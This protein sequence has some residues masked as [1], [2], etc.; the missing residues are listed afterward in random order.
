MKKELT[1]D[2]N[3]INSLLIENGIDSNDKTLY[4]Y[5]CSSFCYATK[6]EIDE[7]LIGFLDKVNDLSKGYII[8]LL[9]LGIDDMRYRLICDSVKNNTICEHRKIRFAIIANSISHMSKTFIDDFVRISDEI[10]LFV[11]DED[12]PALVHGIPSSEDDFNAIVMRIKG[13]LACEKK[14][15]C[16]EH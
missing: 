15:L 14:R 4:A 12:L 10:D 8:S 9:S 11:D 6:T 7:W 2:F 3:M 1:H 13:W 5:L 16:G